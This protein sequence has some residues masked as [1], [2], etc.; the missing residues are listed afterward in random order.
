MENYCWLVDLLDG[1][2]NFIYNNVFYCV[3]IVF[4]NKE[5]LLVGVV[6]EVCCDEFYWIYKGV[7]FYL[8]NKEIYVLDVFD[9]DEVFVVLGFLYDL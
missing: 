8:N 5:E 3:S 9:M 2:I 4:C 1:I 6:Y 7:F